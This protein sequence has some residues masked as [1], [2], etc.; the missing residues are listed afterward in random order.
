[1]LRLWPILWDWGRDRKERDWE[2]NWKSK[3]AEQPEGHSA[4]LEL[5][6][7]EG[8]VLPCTCVLHGGLELLAQVSPPQAS[9]SRSGYPAPSNPLRS[10]AAPGTV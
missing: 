3:L 10:L 4:S 2:E 7:I 8:S 1:M 5:V 6:A 9:G